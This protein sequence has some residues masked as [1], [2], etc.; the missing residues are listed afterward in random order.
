VTLLHV[1]LAVERH[2]SPRLGSFLFVF[3]VVKGAIWCIW[4]YHSL[5]PVAYIRK[6]L[7]ILLLLSEIFDDVK[8]LCD[9]PT[10]RPLHALHFVCPSVRPRL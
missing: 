2:C 8:L 7:L 10:I 5:L 3:V 6:R 4:K 9:C 1:Q